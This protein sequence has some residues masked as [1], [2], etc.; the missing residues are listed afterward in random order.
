MLN[1]VVNQLDSI[2]FDD[3]IK[4][5]TEILREIIVR[6]I[7]HSGFDWYN[8]SK[9][10]SMFTLLTFQGLWKLLCTLDVNVAKTVYDFRCSLFRLR[11]FISV[12]AGTLAGQ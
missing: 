4:R 10:K 11:G 1:D 6:G 5:K 3:Y 7:M 2:L 12:G 8:V 9:P